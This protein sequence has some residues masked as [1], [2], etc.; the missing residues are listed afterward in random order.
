MRLATSLLLLYLC[1]A[2]HLTTLPDS[3]DA[4]SYAVP[5]VEDCGSSGAGT[6]ICAA[7]RDSQQKA[8]ANAAQ[9]ET[10]RL[11]S[12]NIAQ[13]ES[14][15]AITGPAVAV[16]QD[17]PTVQEVIDDR[18]TKYKETVSACVPACSPPYA[19]E[20]GR[21]MFP[22]NDVTEHALPASACISEGFE[23]RDDEVCAE[24]TAL[25]KQCITARKVGESCDTSALQICA[26]GL[27]CMGGYCVSIV[28]EGSACDEH[29]V[30]AG[31]SSG[32]VCAGQKGRTICMRPVGLGHPCGQYS[33]RGWPCDK[34]FV[35][36]AS[37]CKKRLRVG[38]PC[39]SGV[40]ECPAGTLCTAGKIGRRCVR[41]SGNFGGSAAGENASWVIFASRAPSVA[42]WNGAR[43]ADNF[44]GGEYT[45]VKVSLEIGDVLAFRV[46]R[47]VDPDADEAGDDV[48]WNGLVAAVIGRVE[49]AGEGGRV[50]K[51]L[52]KSGDDTE[53]DLESEERKRKRFWYWRG[54]ILTDEKQKNNSKWMLPE[55]NDG[56]CKDNI[57]EDGLDWS[58]LDPV[59]LRANAEGFARYFPGWTNAKYVL[60]EGADVSD[61]MQI[62]VRF[63]MPRC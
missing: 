57:G 33:S 23:C 53:D 24:T 12:N 40:T 29:S 43:L 48:L 20:N 16:V 31:A 17:M 8:N 22:K 38:Q 44:G 14:E 26:S 25:G 54:R 37:V 28:P 1:I 36:R 50:A 45:A 11:S 32:V 5:P 35:C 58:E 42:Y 62:K 4:Y 41:L 39:G 13:A 30:C 60:A 47:L 51:W 15:R 9:V 56:F 6:G 49:G 61:H 34:G 18:G 21:C 10:E 3:T 52:A 59:D 2:L 63:G 55:Y 19:C 7:R 27:G 46:F